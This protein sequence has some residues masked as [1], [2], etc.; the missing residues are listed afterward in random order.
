[1][2]DPFENLSAPA[3]SD[4]E[5]VQPTTEQP[6]RRSIRIGLAFLGILALVIS[7]WVL[8]GGDFNH[9]NTSTLTWVVIAVAA[10]AGLS[11]IASGWRKQR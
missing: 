4:I 3:E 6:E 1:M 7:G 9:E 8:G 11:L 5:T 2:T 10:T